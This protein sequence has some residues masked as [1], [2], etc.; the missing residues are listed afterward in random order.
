MI[1]Q[2]IQEQELDL[3]E[4]FGAWLKHWHFVAKIT[5][6]FGVLAVV[7]CLVVSPTY[8]AVSTVWIRRDKG[9][10]SSILENTLVNDNTQL[11]NTY[12]EVF[13]SQEVLTPVVAKYPKYG[14][15]NGLRGAVQLNIVRNTNLF[16][17][18]VLD[19]DPEQAK[20]VNDDLLRS[21]VEHLSA[22]DRQQFS[23]TRAFLD[24]RVN[25]FRQE[26]Y[27][28]EDNLQR[29]EKEHKIM[30]Q[31]SAVTM[32]MNRLSSTDE[33]KVKNRINL[34]VANAKI[35]VAQQQMRGKNLRAIADSPTLTKLREELG[36]LEKKRVE[37]NTRY[38][39][40]H[41]LMVQLN[42][43]IRSLRQ[44][45][46]QEITRV[47]NLDMP[48]TGIYAEIYQERLKNEAEARVAQSN[49][50]SIARIE[51][52]FMTD[53]S[54]MSDANKEHLRL[55]RDV[56]VAQEIYTILAKRFEE[57][58]VAEVSVSQEARIA[59][60]ASVER[61]PVAPKKT[62]TVAI[63]LFLGFVLSSVFV[64]AREIMN[65]TIAS[66][67]DVSKYLDLP[68]LGVVPDF[69]LMR[70]HLNRQDKDDEDED[71]GTGTSSRLK[72]LQKQ[73]QKLVRKVGV[74]L[75]Q[76]K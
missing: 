62:R 11:A 56:T 1:N 5:G 43:N 52:D 21:F 6:I 25:D 61:T 32:A 31:D 3:L 71:E 17:V 40:K 38:T 46:D 73:A 63:A 34:E 53:I 8:Q 9:I 13:R 47:A 70:E 15:V 23:V 58:K 26:L 76:M 64:V 54:K 59:S 72:R 44:K 42:N 41:P 22:I 66:P 49:L 2:D 20:N 12:M 74:S 57:A 68:V 30:A 33:M 50:D 29:F 39:A 27:R 75:W 35:E 67:E 37:W 18:T 4:C 69:D 65:R 16:S 14:S 60:R 48:P 7:Y 10:G 24:N 51:R 55:L 36:E 19:R 45:M 28:A